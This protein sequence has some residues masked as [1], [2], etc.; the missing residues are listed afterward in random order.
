M[1]WI[2][3]IPDG[4]EVESDDF[5]LDDLDRIERESGIFWS[6]ANPLREAKVAR[7]FLKAAYRRAGLDEDLVDSL[8][9][10]QIKSVFRYRPDERAGGDAETPTKAPRGRKRKPSSGGAPNGTGGPRPSPEPSGTA[11]S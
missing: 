5:L 11:T 3:R 4:P 6:V 9:M 7:A 10:G 1:T 8:R 2:I